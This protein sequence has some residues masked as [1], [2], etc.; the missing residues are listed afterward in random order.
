M[1]LDS[2]LNRGSEIVEFF[3]KNVFEEVEF[4]GFFKNG[5]NRALT[6]T[7]RNFKFKK[8]EFSSSNHT[9]LPKRIF[10]YRKKKKKKL[11]I[12]DKILNH[13]QQPPTPCP[14]RT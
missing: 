7:Q 14:Q 11:K 9:Y 8:K 13:G 6:H 10:L 4:E 12:L 5:K 3:L 2:I 1:E